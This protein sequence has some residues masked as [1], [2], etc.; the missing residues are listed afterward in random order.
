MSK[1]QD[2]IQ[3]YPKSVEVLYLIIIGFAYRT[4]IGVFLGYKRASFIEIKIAHP[5]TE[6]AITKIL[7]EIYDYNS[8]S[9]HGAIAIFIMSILFSYSTTR[10]KY[11]RFIIWIF[12]V[13]AVV[14]NPILQRLT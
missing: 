11:F 8:V 10:S 1:I 7:S 5:D 4:T 2:G 12:G 6:P 9:Y 14:I 3:K 13:I